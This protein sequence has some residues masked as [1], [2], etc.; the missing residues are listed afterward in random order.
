VF[1]LQTDAT[2]NTQ[3]KNNQEK[4]KFF[5]QVFLP[6]LFPPIGDRVMALYQYPQAGDLFTKV[7]TSLTKHS[8]Y[9][10][11]GSFKIRDIPRI[12]ERINPPAGAAVILSR[13]NPPQSRA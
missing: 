10:T 8:L 4:K 9:V 12:A 13:G 7:S 3:K 6:P 1:F 2:P 11:G 5:L